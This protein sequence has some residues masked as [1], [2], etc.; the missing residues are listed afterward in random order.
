MA[1]TPRLVVLAAVAVL[2]LAGGVALV[3]A[4]EEGA[5]TL[6]MLSLHGHQPTT[7][8]TLKAETKGDQ[9]AEATTAVNGVASNKRAKSHSGASASGAARIKDGKRTASSFISDAYA[10]NDANTLVKN[11]AKS[12]IGFPSEEEYD[13]LLAENEMLRNELDASGSAD[14]D[15]QSQLDA[16]ERANAD[17]QSQLDTS[18]SLGADLQTALTERENENML[19]EQA[20]E[21]QE[22]T[23]DA[24]QSA[25]DA[26]DAELESVKDQIADATSKKADLEMQLDDAQASLV[27]ITDVVATFNAELQ[28]CIGEKAA[29]NSE[30]ESCTNVLENTLAEITEITPCPT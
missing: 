27:S 15:L 1:K 28:Q 21:A 6:A 5:S 20:L 12:T 22:S 29:L 9:N 7:M 30:Q 18:E 2:A 16:S 23:N 14:A 13:H 4:A 17:L 24:L 3:S 11:E 8:T 10:L 19:V 26:S 25:L